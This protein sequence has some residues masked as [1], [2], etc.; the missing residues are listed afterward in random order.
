[1]SRRKNAPLIKSEKSRIGTTK[2]NDNFAR[3]FALY[4][5]MAK[6]VREANI[7]HGEGPRN[8]SR[9]GWELLQKPGVAKRYEHWLAVFRKRM[10]ISDNRILAEI[11]SVALLDPGTL[12]RETG[13]LSSMDE[14]PEHVRRAVKKVRVKR[15]VKSVDPDTEI[16][17]NE[18]VIEYEFHDKL[19]A[20]DLMVRINGLE[21]STEAPKAITVNVRKGGRG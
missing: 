2:Q 4:S 19:R 3:L 12:Y 21:T 5:S 10:D 20:L 14:L 11:A 16:V 1:M 15:T 9:L 6:A 8:A 17:T 13:G 18:D 7:P